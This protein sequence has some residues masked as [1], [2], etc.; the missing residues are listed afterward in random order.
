MK[1]VKITEKGE[2]LIAT[3]TCEIDHHTAKIIREEID[4]RLDAS[5]AGVLVLDFSGVGFMDSSGIGLILGRLSR[6]EELGIRVHLCGL[7]ATLSRLVRMSGIERLKSITV[8][9]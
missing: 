3:L 9:V 1:E 8:E 7:S 6:A 5:H 2:R 4:K